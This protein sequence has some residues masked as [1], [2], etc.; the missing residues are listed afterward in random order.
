MTILQAG[1]YRLLL[2]PRERLRAI[3]MSM[4]VCVSVC[5]TVREDISGTTRAIFRPTELFAHVAYVRGPVLFWPV[6]DR[7][8]RLSVGRG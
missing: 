5:L 3:V 1:L 4:S 7:P 6:D 2:R 8:H